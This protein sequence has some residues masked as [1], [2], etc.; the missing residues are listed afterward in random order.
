MVVT[1]EWNG[2]GMRVLGLYNPNLNPKLKSY[3]V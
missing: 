1:L 3:L 2:V